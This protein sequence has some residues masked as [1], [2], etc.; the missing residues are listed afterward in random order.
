MI[1]CCV[2]C[3]MTSNETTGFY[4]QYMNISSSGVNKTQ[5]KVEFTLIL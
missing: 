1:T 3:S 5:H 2:I 4:L